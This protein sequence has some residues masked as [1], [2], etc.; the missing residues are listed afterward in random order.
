MISLRLYTDWGHV[1]RPADPEQRF[2][3]LPLDGISPEGEF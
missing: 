1:G 2:G 3:T